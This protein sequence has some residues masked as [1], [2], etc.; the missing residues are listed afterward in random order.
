MAERGFPLAGSNINTEDDWSLAVGKM[1]TNGVYSGFLNALAVSANGLSMG[2]TVASGASNTGGFYYQ[3]DAAR[4]LAFTTAHAT[5]PRIDTVVVRL[6]R[7]VTPPIYTTA[8]VAG[9]PNGSPVAPTLT[10]TIGVLGTPTIYELPLADVR[11]NAA[12]GTITADKVTDRR[13]YVVPALSAGSIGSSLLAAGAVTPDKLSISYQQT[14][15]ADTD[16]IPVRGYEV[17]TGNWQTTYTYDA[18]NRVQTVTVKDATGTTT[19]SVTT[20]VYNTDGTIASETEV[21]GGR[22]VVTTYAYVPG[23]PR[24]ATETRSVT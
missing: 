22:T 21:A 20:Y 9:T 8:V 24:I 13:T 4:T 10:Q 14:G 12:V 3:S 6:N 11:V 2:V 15:T 19:V 18:A 5:L 17:D 1:A 7:T 23:T 16:V